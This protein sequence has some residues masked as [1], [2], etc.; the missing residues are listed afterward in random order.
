MI[1]CV[2]GLVFS[3]FSK[4]GKVAAVK[5]TVNYLTYDN[6]QNL[7]LKIEQNSKHYRHHSNSL[8]PNLVLTYQVILGS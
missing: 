7:K 6:G 3:I 1:L 8:G 2:S 4:W 5:Y